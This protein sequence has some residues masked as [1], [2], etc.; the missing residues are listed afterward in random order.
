MNALS[1]GSFGREV[2]TSDRSEWNAL[3]FRGLWASNEQQSNARS[4]PHPAPRSLPGTFDDCSS[5]L[6][7]RA[8]P[9]LRKRLSAAMER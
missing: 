9:R 2:K 6:K 7:N 4:L 1:F 8:P 5:R 3:P